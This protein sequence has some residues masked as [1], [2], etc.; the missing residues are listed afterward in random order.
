MFREMF[1]SSAYQLK[2]V[3]FALRLD[4]EGIVDID[5]RVGVT[6]SQSFKVMLYVDYQVVLRCESANP[7]RGSTHATHLC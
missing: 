6:P 4:I 3:G 5:Q 1:N 7:E 2:N